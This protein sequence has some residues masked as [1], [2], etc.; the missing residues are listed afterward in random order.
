MPKVSVQQKKTILLNNFLTSQKG[1]TRKQISQHWQKYRSKKHTIVEL[2]KYRKKLYKLKSQ[3]KPEKISELREKYFD[4]KEIFV[5]KL[6]YGDLKITKKHKQ[7][8]SEQDFYSVRKGKHLDPIISKIF[9]DQ[10]K[11]V[12]YILVTLKI[13]LPETGQVMYVSDTLNPK[14]F[15]RMQSQGETAMSK[16]LEKLSFVAKYDGFEIISKHLRL[17]YALPETSKKQKEN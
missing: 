11:K 4:R 1:K 14:S 3:N 7:K 15:E 6:E 8:F 13:R 9:A 10:K 17:I 12:R 5:R 16:V 2:P